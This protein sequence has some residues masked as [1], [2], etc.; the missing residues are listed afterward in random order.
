MMSLGLVLNGV[1]LLIGL[2][3]YDIFWVFGTNDELGLFKL[4]LCIR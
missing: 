3:F 4:V 1:I 2:F